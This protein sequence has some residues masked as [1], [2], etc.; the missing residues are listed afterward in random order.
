MEEKA[1]E[2]LERIEKERG[3]RSR[4]RRILAERDP[5]FM[6]G[7][8]KLNMH[9]LYREDG[10]PRK[11]VELVQ[12]VTNALSFYE[13][14]FKI[15]LRNGLKEGLTEVE[16]IQALEICTLSGIHYMTSTLP[17]LEDEVGKFKERAE[18]EQGVN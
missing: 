1:R 18:G 11:Y 16:I 10:L 17:V 12:L 4:W 14:G 5:E 15:H 3:F 2:L 8:H 6:E 9:S 13:P 7:I